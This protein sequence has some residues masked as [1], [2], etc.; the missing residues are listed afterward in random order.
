MHVFSGNDANSLTDIAKLMLMI[1]TGKRIYVDGVIVA[2]P[3]PFN[4]YDTGYCK[5]SM[6]SDT[7][8]IFIIGEINIP[9]EQ[10]VLSFLNSIDAEIQKIQTPLSTMVET[11][12]TFSNNEIPIK[13]ACSSIYTDDDSFVTRR[14][15]KFDTRSSRTSSFTWNVLRIFPSFKDGIRDDKDWMMHQNG[16][17]ID[18][19]NPATLYRQIKSTGT[20]NILK[21]MGIINGKVIHFSTTFSVDTLIPRLND[22]IGF[23]KFRHQIH[24]S[25]E[26]PTMRIANLQS[27]EFVDLKEDH[28]SKCQCCGDDLI[29]PYAYGLKLCDN[30]VIGVCVFCVDRDDDIANVCIQYGIH[31]INCGRELKDV[32]Q[33]TYNISF[34]QMTLVQTRIHDSRFC[35]I[36]VYDN[37]ITINKYRSISYFDMTHLY[38]SIKNGDSDMVIAIS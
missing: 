16:I 17:I 38:N 30:N 31:T 13:Y 8:N 1:E 2:D 19:T 37:V 5:I 10:Y 6:M 33:S 35:T 34:E 28:N 4:I 7:C 25:I 15:F 23:A 20:F 27:M 12:S 36:G 11:K 9:I 14:I 24:C 3:E 32:C 21:D 29:N 18:F 22:D 26:N